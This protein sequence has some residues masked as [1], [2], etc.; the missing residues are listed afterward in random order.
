MEAQRYSFSRWSIELA[1]GWTAEARVEFVAGVRC[2]FVALFPETKDALLRITPDERGLMDAATWV[3]AMGE[4]NRAKGR[5]VVPARCGD[6][7]GYAV[8]FG[9]CDDWLRGWALAIGGFPFDA[10][11]RCKAGN[12]GRDDAV[13]DS[14]LDTL[15]LENTTRVSGNQISN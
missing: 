14:M 13:V 11:Y 12:A 15:R 9:A 8:E 1:T 10:N 3:N 2:E 6:L 7:K 5:S 4:S